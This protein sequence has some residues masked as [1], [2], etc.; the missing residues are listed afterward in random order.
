MVT[1]YQICVRL[2]SGTALSHAKGQTHVYNYSD[3][4]VENKNQVSSD[5]SIGNVSSFTQVS[6]QKRETNCFQLYSVCPNLQLD[7]HN[8][9]VLNHNGKRRKATEAKISPSA[10]FFLP[11]NI[12]YR[13]G[14]LRSL[15]SITR[16][17][18]VDCTCR[19][20]TFPQ[21]TSFCLFSCLW[22]P[23]KVL[24]GIYPTPILGSR[25]FSPSKS[26]QL[27]YR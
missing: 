5:S 27:K 23:S 17:Y 26:H 2:L 24:V 7:Q 20:H 8:I 1:Q 16:M 21:A 11:K 15:L 3:T 14:K 25:I 19:L 12:R 13:G 22:H 6:V 10:T 18:G 4:E 9:L